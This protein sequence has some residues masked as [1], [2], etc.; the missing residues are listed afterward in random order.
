[1]ANPG[2]QGSRRLVVRD[3]VDPGHHPPGGLSHTDRAA[4][5]NHPVKFTALYN[6]KGGVA[7]TTNTF[8]IAWGLAA[9]GESVIMV[10]LDPQRNLTQSVL[11]R[12]ADLNHDGDF[13]ALIR[14]LFNVE[15]VQQAPTVFHY[16]SKL[17]D[18][19]YTFD[20]P[21]ILLELCS[22]RPNRQNH[23]N[24]DGTPQGKG[25]LFLLVGDRRLSQWEEDMQNATRL[26][27]VKTKG[28]HLN[29]PG[30]LYNLLK[31]AAKNRSATHV[32]MDLSPACGPLNKL[33]LLFADDIFV[34][35]CPE[36]FSMEAIESLAEMIPEWVEEVEE[37]LKA[38]E[39]IVESSS[40]AIK[41]EMR[42]PIAST[43]KGILL[44]RFAVGA[45]GKP[46][47]H[48]LAHWCRKLQYAVKDKLIP[49]LRILGRRW[50]QDFHT[51]EQ[52][53]LGTQARAQRLTIMQGT[54]AS[55][56]DYHQL[57]DRVQR[58]STPCAF[59]SEEQLEFTWHEKF[60][61]EWMTP[62]QVELD[63]YE[64]LCQEKLVLDYQLESHIQ[65]LNAEQQARF[66]EL[67]SAMIPAPPMW[68]AQGDL[69]VDGRPDQPNVVNCDTF[70]IK[71]A[72]NL[73]GLKE[74]VE[75]IAAEINAV[76]DSIL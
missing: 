68:P 67:R 65:A 54:A 27:K 2:S 75:I 40:R 34:P 28:A 46:Q 17:Q 69:G 13:Q 73:E 29:Y 35:C 33:S 36:Y 37:L 71:K 39:K 9:R 53:R 22:A 56:K 21:P 31:I 49:R 19:P 32:M 30:G 70:F 18:D 59:L 24:F 76:V 16:L 52:T 5:E 72:S 41:Y 4:Y 45:E 38:Q 11:F 3:P 66:Q 60:Y 50:V 12:E 64:R 26:M 10:D 8:A 63:E 44:T 51:L 57:S 1:M 15:R 6:H 61:E 14:H 74:R 25:H 62:F 55:I 42:H 20:T 48:S 7:K 23:D 58:Y 47:S 43:F